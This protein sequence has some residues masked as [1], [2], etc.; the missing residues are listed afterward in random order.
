MRFSRSGNRWLSRNFDEL[1]YGVT[2][3]PASVLTWSVGYFL[4]A[5]TS[6]LWLRSCIRV[7]TRIALGCMTL[8]DPM[9][10]RRTAALDAIGSHYFIGSRSEHQT[11][12]PREMIAY[13]LGADSRK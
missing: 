2:T 13:Y 1:D 6:R 5:W 11:I 8:F 9:L 4:H 10:A 12:T 7:L 3:G